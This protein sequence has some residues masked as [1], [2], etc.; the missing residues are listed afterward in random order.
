MQENFDPNTIQDLDGARQAINH[1]LNLI[2]D[3]TADLREAQAEIQRLRD[4]N[5]RLKGEQGKPTIK[6][7]KTQTPPKPSDHSSERER[8]KP[9]EWKKRSKVDQIQ[10]DREQVLPIDPLVLPPDAEFKGHDPVVVQDLILRTD[11]VR[12]LKEKYYS[13]AQGQSYLAELPKGYAG[14][15]GPG[16]K[17]TVLVWYYGMNTSEPKILELLTQVGIHISAGQ[18]SNLLI[19][20]Q[21]AFHAEKTAVYE[22]GL[23]ASPYQNIDDTAT[24]V[25][26]VNQH[27][28]VVGS[29]LYTAY[30][31]M[32]KKDR[33]AVLDVLRNDAPRVYRLNVQAYTW[34]EPFGLP[35]TTLAQ[36]RMLPQEHDLSETEFARYLDEQ[37]P[38]LGSLDRKHI[39][40]AAAV[41][42]YHHQTTWPVVDT[43]VCDD[44][45]QFKGLTEQ[46]SLCWV[47]DGRH[48]KKLE[49]AVALHRQQ[50]DTFLGRY[51]A[52]YDKLLDY[53]VQPSGEHA[54]QLSQAFDAL[55]AT[56]TGYTAL[57]ERIAKTKAKKTQLLLVLEHP[58]I[59]LHNN[60]AELGAR[61]R[62]RKR[63]VSYGPRTSTGKKAWDT[64]MTLGATTKKLGVSFYQYI[65]DRVSGN[66]QLPNLSDLV[67]RQAEQRQLGASWRPKATLP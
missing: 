7:N 3:L 35:A 36:L 14:E 20:K 1:L 19:Q 65:Y 23:R 61:L 45:G 17:S 40:E 24:R 11:N 43:L 59:P 46:L 29:P 13:P 57:D 16:V 37:R 2:E 10:I 49:P 22:A 32:E 64:F 27:C 38:S 55:F 53:P 44:A 42:A 39:V 15:F 4:E 31:T 48:Y 9:Q 33:L 62:V 30:F 50:L 58:E 8:H 52:F 5:N 25:D 66:R 18:L 34:L 28:H 21:D 41:A 51:W 12:F 54:A 6:P 56:V 63:D 67:S 47:H 60:L 26:G